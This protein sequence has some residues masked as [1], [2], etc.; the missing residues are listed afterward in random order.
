MNMSEQ[1]MA[2]WLGA[3]FL[4][5]VSRV[6][7]GIAGAG[8]LGSNCAM[9][10]VRSGFRRFLVADFDRVEPSNLNRQCF[11]AD[12]VGQ[13]KV[14]ALAENLRRVNPDVVVDARP[15]RVEAADAADLFAG[16]DAVV[17]AFDDPACKKALVEAVV[18]SGRLVVA[19]SGIGGCGNSDAVRIRRMLPNFHLV[20]DMETEC[21]VDDPPLSPTVGVVAAKQ[22]D[23]VLH[24]FFERYKQG[25]T[26]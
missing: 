22:A 15:V 2:T 16:C 5:F 14:E 25:E 13:L 4:D 21:S 11:F 10:L 20:G 3:G 7:V 9:H 6:T 24:H 23:V 18:P 17:E 1:G 26:A 19:A 12:Q 8:G